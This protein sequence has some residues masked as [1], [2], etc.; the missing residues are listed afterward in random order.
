M[1]ERGGATN[2]RLK[3]MWTLHVTQL[4]SEEMLLD[5]LLD[6]DAYVRAWAVQLALE[7][8]MASE[9]LR[10][11]LE[12]MAR[13][14]ASPVVRKYL[15]AAL[16]RLAPEDRMVLAAIL[17]G[18]ADDADDHNIPTLI[19]LGVEPLVPE[20]PEEAMRLAGISRMPLIT[21]SIARRLVD[22]DAL[23]ELARG[24]RTMPGA[25][26]DLLVGMLAGLE[27]RHDLSAPDNWAGVYRALRKDDDAG[28]LAL[29]VAQ[30]FGDAEAARRM[31]EVAQDIGAALEERR[32]ALRSLAQ[33]RRAGLVDALPA[34]LEEP[35]LRAEAIRAIA[36]F[37][38]QELGVLLM[39]RYAALTSE[40]KSEAIRTLASRPL[41]G[42]LLTDALVEGA[43]PRSDVP[44]YV[45]RQL[46]RVVGS[47]FVEVW[48]PIDQLPGDKELAFERFR[49]LLTE[50]AIG[51]ADASR[52]KAVF[53]R[54][55]AAC[56]QMYG[57]GGLIGPELTGSNRENL[58]YIL[59]NM[60]SP[61][62]EIH[63][64]Y[65]MVVVTTRDGRTYLGNIIA[66]S[67]RQMTLR[68]VGQPPAVLNKSDLQSREVSNV[69]LMPEGLL[70][71]LSD[72]EVLDLVAY[73]RTSEQ[74]P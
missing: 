6:P 39:E 66:E 2:L 59:S 62:E 12:K 25:R 37:E 50:E 42:W 73:F 35:L 30:H 34:L 67:D 55:C 3:A 56:H 52:G 72:G 54:A 20:R 46:R 53:V 24:L 16:Q 33:G 23:E 9:A 48:G 51:A 63:D 28:P 15:A 65:R 10:A 57:E 11:R 74:A 22:A 21:Q 27:G 44:P 29:E 14:E 43:I 4:L 8:Q 45:A 49:A 69:S 17:L 32:S 60:I 7:D 26:R 71:G 31:L 58:D 38:N 36:A 5:A 13:R 61:S 41:Y 40:E 18:H 19:W 64:D 68:L 47:G 70:G 1:F